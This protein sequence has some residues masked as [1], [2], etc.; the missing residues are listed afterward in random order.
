[1]STR[2]RLMAGLCLAGIAVC[3]AALLDHKP[4]SA[5]TPNRA[6]SALTVSVKNGW[7]QP[8]G[9]DW[10]AHTVVLTKGKSMICIQ[11][12]PLPDLSSLDALDSRRPRFFAQRFSEAWALPLQRRDQSGMTQITTAEHVGTGS[13]TYVLSAVSR[14]AESKV[15]ADVPKG[16]AISDVKQA[17][18]QAL[19]TAQMGDARP[20]LFARVPGPAQWDRQAGQVVSGRHEIIERLGSTQ[21]RIPRGWYPADLDLPTGAALGPDLYPRSTLYLDRI[22]PVT[23]EYSGSLTVSWVGPGDGPLFT[24]LH[25]ASTTLPARAKAA[26]ETRRTVEIDDRHEAFAISTA[27]YPDQVRYRFVSAKLVVLSTGYSTKAG[28][29]SALD[30]PAMSIFRQIVASR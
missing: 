19:G 10:D 28:S 11:A 4:G 17:I 15:V 22:D 13:A 25:R 1:M 16:T 27:P 3:G 7:Q 18:W 21:I 6:R 5:R 30:A 14:L 12:Y 29:A 8:P 26:D 2:A 9:F 24:K 20:R 23:R